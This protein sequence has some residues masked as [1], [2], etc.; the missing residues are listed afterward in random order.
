LALLGS[1][2]VVEKL[3]G[4]TADY[5]GEGLQ[6]WTQ[7]KV[8]NVRR[9]FSKA[10]HR[11]GRELDNQGAVPPRVLRGIIDDGSFCDDELSAEYFGGVLASSR[12]EVARDDRAASLIALLS[13]LSTYQIRAH[14]ILCTVF[15]RLYDGSGLGLSAADQQK[16]LIFIPYSSYDVAMGFSDEEKRKSIALLE[17][18]FFGLQRETLVGWAA[19]GGPEVLLQTHGLGLG[20]E[21][22]VVYRP[23][24]LAT[25]LYLWAHGQADLGASALLEPDRTFEVE[26]P[27]EIPSG[28][29]K[30]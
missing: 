2:K 18:V 9:I 30:L 7:H 11:I 21:G 16:V 28:Y 17:H 12:S 5:I 25:E 15:K 27:I 29:F 26:N 4:P 6:H 20:K 1:A 24:A 3:L 13:R 14:Y 19:Y 22:G 8:D 10:T 23:S